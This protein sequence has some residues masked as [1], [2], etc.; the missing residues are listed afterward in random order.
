[1]PPGAETDQ[2]GVLCAGEGVGGSGIVGIHVIIGIDEGDELPAGELE[3]P[4]ASG[5]QTAMRCPEG[6]GKTDIAMSH[7]FDDRPGVVLGTIVNRNYLEV[8]DSHG[9]QGLEAPIQ[10]SRSVI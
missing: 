4:V 1:F 6:A 7:F 5:A 3:A 10:K 2:I 9:R 8:L